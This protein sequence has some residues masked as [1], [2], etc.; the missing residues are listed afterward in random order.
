M[1]ICIHEKHRELAEKFHSLHG[2]RI[3]SKCGLLLYS[4]K[5]FQQNQD[6]I[7]IYSRCGNSMYFEKKLRN[8]AQLIQIIL[9]IF[10]SLSVYCTQRQTVI[11]SHT[12][13]LIAIL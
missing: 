12:M 7:N 9:E 8:V 4:K 2:S 11:I 6:K 13:I 5:E 1:S 3:Y 10:L